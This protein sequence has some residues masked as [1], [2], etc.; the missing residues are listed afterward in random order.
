MG[1]DEDGWRQ[2]FLCEFLDE[3]SAFLT[4][5]MIASCEDPLAGNAD[6]L[7]VGGP[8]YVGVDIGRRHDLTVIW[9]LEIAG[10]VGWTRRVTRLKNTPF[11]A[12]VEFLRSVLRH[13]RVVRSSIDETGIGMQLAENMKADFPGKV[14]PV[15]FSIATKAPMAEAL[16]TDFEDRTLRIPIDGD[17]RTSLHSVKRVATTGGNFRY[18]AERNE[19]GHADEFWALALA[20][21]AWK[22]GFQAVKGL[23]LNLYGRGL[24]RVA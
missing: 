11:R 8:I 14:E 19:A 5:E 24:S 1:N 3:V 15:T 10:D 23:P 7:I 9:E 20:R 6:R 2:E 4:H 17:I 13:P 22:G 16:K 18:D 21:D 12:Q